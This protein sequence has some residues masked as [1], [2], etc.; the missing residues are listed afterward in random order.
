M[1]TLLDKRS[2]FNSSRDSKCSSGEISPYDNNSPVLSEW[3]RP[4]APERHG[5][6]DVTDALAGNVTVDFC[7]S[8]SQADA[9]EIV[10]VTAWPIQV[11]TRL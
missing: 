11:L 8:P 2:Y 10:I 4:S 5:L 9:G 1:N 6:T 3:F 7:L